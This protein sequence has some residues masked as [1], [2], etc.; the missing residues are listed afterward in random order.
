[1]GQAQR[2]DPKRRGRRNM[3]GGSSLK[4]LDDMV[5]NMACP[6][7]G[8]NDLDRIRTP[9]VDLHEPGASCPIVRLS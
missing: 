3:R 1:M 4:L 8:F 5:V 7:V 2:A 6:R 9:V